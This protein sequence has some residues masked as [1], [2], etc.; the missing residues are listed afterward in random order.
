[1]FISL[2]KLVL[3][4]KIIFRE[5]SNLYKTKITNNLNIFS[6]KRV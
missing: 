5:K 3:I 4:N 1:M 2:L 6:E